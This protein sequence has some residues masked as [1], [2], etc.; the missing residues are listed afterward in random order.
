[1]MEGGFE[2]VGGF[3]GRG[4]IRGITISGAASTSLRLDALPGGVLGVVGLSPPISEVHNVSNSI[5]VSLSPL[6]FLV[7]VSPEFDVVENI[8]TA[9]DRWR[10]SIKRESIVTEILRQHWCVKTM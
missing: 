8:P 1:M 7:A 9:V 4:R 5:T 3:D 10:L 2:C 6:R